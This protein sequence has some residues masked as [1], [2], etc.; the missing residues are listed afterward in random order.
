VV[1]KLRKALVKDGWDNM[2]SSLDVLLDGEQ[3]AMDVDMAIMEKAEVFIG[4][5]MSPFS[6]SFFHRC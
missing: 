1:S 2:K 4:N 3:V 5:G 6:S